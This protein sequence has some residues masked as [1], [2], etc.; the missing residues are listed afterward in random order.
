MKKLKETRRDAK[1]HEETCVFLSCSSEV[2]FRFP[3]SEKNIKKWT[4]NE[5][6]ERKSAK[7]KSGKAKSRA[8][9][10]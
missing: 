8:L 2:I 7:V 10:F 5:K 4:I 3:K 6:N 1:K 9:W